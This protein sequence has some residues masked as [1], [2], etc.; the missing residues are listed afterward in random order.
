MAVADG[1]RM[2]GFM[3]YSVEKIVLNTHIR[4]AQYVAGDNVRLTSSLLYG[5]NETNTFNNR[6]GMISGVDIDFGSRSCIVTILFLPTLSQRS[7]R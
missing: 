3:R 4:M 1:T 2:E 6:I 7:F 5:T